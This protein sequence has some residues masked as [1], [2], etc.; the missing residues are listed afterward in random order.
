[1]STSKSIV[2]TVEQRILVVRVLLI[3]ISFYQNTKSP[4]KPS[5]IWTSNGYLV[6]M[7]HMHTYN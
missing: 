6:A 5:L 1:M 7:A 4:K 3:V 2:E